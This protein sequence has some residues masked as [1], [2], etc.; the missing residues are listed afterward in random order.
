MG[1]FIDATNQGLSYLES[2][3]AEYV[4]SGNGEVYENEVCDHP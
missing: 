2:L 1:L 4:A 3:G